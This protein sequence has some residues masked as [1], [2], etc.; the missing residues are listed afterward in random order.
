MCKIL[1]EEYKFKV[2][3][4]RMP[5]RVSEHKGNIWVDMRHVLKMHTRVYPENLKGREASRNL[6]LDWRIV[7]KC[8]LMNRV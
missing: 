2:V 4:K 5:R 7:L 6:S 1:K 3:E 8:T